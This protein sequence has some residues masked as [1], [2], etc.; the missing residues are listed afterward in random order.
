MNN[1][2]PL[3]TYGM[4]ENEYCEMLEKLSRAFSITTDSIDVLLYIAIPKII[5]ARRNSSYMG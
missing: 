3:N 1:N 5:K 2:K 4:T